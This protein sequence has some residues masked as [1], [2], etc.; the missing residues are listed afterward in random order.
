MI[1]NMVTICAKLME[2]L[3][4]PPEALAGGGGRLG[5]GNDCVCSIKILIL[6][7]HQAGI[8]GRSRKPYRYFG[9]IWGS[10]MGKLS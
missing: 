4:L 7:S 6:I 2:S 3:H 8:E 10:G 1:L 9:P 5:E